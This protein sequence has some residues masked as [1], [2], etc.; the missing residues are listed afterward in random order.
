MSQGKRYKFPGSSF[1]VQTGLAATT[2]ITA[3]TQANPGVVS[4]A[5]HGLLEGDV[6]KLAAIVGMTQLN[7]NLYVVD[8]PA[9]GTFELMDTDTTDYTAYTSGGTVAKVNFTNF[10][11]LTNYNQQDGAAD[12]YDATT[13]CSTVKEFEVGLSDPGTLQIDYL[14]AG[15]QPVQAALKAAKISGDIIAFK[16]QLP[17]DGG[18]I[19]CFGSVQQQSLT[20]GNGSLWVGS[21]T[22]R[23]TGDITYLPAA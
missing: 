4:S 13:I 14:Y 21:A 8:D 19:I 23:L 17:K 2:A 12:E 7:N 11:E 22:I 6:A 5:A 18:T 10:C 3:I 16:L 9:A 20:G 15:A 1:A